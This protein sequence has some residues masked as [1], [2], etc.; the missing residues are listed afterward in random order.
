MSSLEKRIEKLLSRISRLEAKVNGLETKVTFLDAA[1]FSLK[2]ENESLRTENESL[3][4]E[5]VRLKKGTDSSNSSKPPS[6]DPNK[7]KGKKRKKTGGKKV[8]GQKGHKG[9]NLEFRVNP[10]HTVEHV[11]QSCSGCGACLANEEGKIVKKA[12]VIDIPPIQSE[13]TEHQQILT[14]CSRCGMQNT[15][16]LPGTLDYAAVQYGDN[17]RQLITYLSVHQYLPMARISELIEAMCGERLSTG[18]IANTIEEYARKLE[19]VYLKIKDRISQSKVVGS[20]ETGARIN[21]VNAY[22]WTWQTDK[23]NFQFASDNRGF[24]TVEYCFEDGLPNSI[25]V[26]DRYGSQLKTEAKANQLCIAHLLR[27]CKKLIDHYESDWAKRFKSLLLKIH[28]LGSKSKLHKRKAGKLV[29][30][31]DR[32]LTEDISKEHDEVKTFH[33]SMTKH[34]DKLTTCLYHVEVPTTNNASERAIRNIKVKQKIS[35][36]FRSWKGA[37]NF[38]IIR[39]VIDTAIKQSLDPFKV[40]FYPELVLNSPE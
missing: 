2:K 19:E 39:S 6:S 21:G 27:D 10:D 9:K 34:K 8:G 3:K 12:Q 1:N 20:D 18:T 25:L 38:T 40:L 14:E 36:S 33:K 7:K 22:I 16:K 24:R 29:K 32:L 28:E 4:A 17:I 35:T 11:A 31:L 5:I 26:S 15:G 37:E 30:R 23:Y 13:V